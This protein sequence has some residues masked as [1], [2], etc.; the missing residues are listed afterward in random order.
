MN[1]TDKKHFVTNFPYIKKNLKHFE[2]YAYLAH[3]RLERVFGKKDPT[4]LYECYNLISLLAGSEKYYKLFKDIF[5]IVRKYS[6]TKK[7]L[8]IQCWLNIHNSNEVLQWHTHYDSLFHGYISINPKNTETEFEQYKIKNKIGNVYIG[9]S[10][11]HH[12]VKINKFFDGKRITI[13]FDVFDENCVKKMYE[14]DGKLM[15]NISFI[16][17]Y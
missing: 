17:I 1:I 6:N 9:P 4:K 11:R 13:G 15:L 10:N 16:P 14:R 7:P 12:K 3:E 2:D 8:W 5:L